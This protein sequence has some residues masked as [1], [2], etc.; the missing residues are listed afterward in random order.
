[1]T[2]SGI[3]ALPEWLR[4]SVPEIRVPAHISYDEDRNVYILTDDNGSTRTF[5]HIEDAYDAPREADG[6]VIDENVPNR[7]G[8]F[9]VS[10]P[11]DR[12]GFSRMLTDYY[13]GQYLDILI[14]DYKDFFKTAENFRKNPTDF[15]NAYL[16]VSHHPAFWTKVLRP[17]ETATDRVLMWKTENDPFP[18]VILNEDGTHGWFIEAGQHIA[19]DFTDTYYDPRLDVAADTVEEVVIMCAQLVEKFFN[20]DGT[21]KKGVDS[22]H[23]DSRY[24]IPLERIFEDFDSNNSRNV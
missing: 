22:G 21:E 14:S 6:I 4:N 18:E 3:D 19:P 24:D 16:F 5:P 10:V 17:G 8:S 15:R 2:D 11:T 7:K 23:V 20:D 1:M 13:D 9:F 12:P